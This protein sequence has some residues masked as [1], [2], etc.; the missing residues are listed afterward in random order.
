MPAPEGPAFTA[1]LHDGP[2]RGLRV[3][4]EIVQGRPPCTIDVPNGSAG[5]CRY[6]LKEWGETGS[7]AGYTYLYAV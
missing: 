6:C 7:T 1:L 2:L 5:V 3:P 4:T